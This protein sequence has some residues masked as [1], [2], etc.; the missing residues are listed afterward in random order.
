[1]LLDSIRD[2]V[3]TVSPNRQYLG[4]LI[5]TIPATQDPTNSKNS[6]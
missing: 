4:I 2:D 1:M 6:I 3:L 5:P